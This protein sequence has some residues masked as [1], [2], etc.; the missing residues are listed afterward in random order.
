MSKDTSHLGG[1]IKQV[2][3]LVKFTFLVL[4]VLI[5]VL[6]GTVMVLF[7]LYRHEKHR[8]TQSQSATGDAAG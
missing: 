2:A 5:T 8:D 3:N 1:L 7:S 4:I 6:A